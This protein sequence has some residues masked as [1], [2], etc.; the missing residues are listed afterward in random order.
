[1]MLND[2]LPYNCYHSVHVIE[3]LLRACFKYKK[4]RLTLK[5]PTRIY[6]C[7]NTHYSSSN[8]RPQIPHNIFTAYSNGYHERGSNKWLPAEPPMSMLYQS[9]FS[10]RN[11]LV[12]LLVCI[13]WILLL[14]E[15]RVWRLSVANL[16]F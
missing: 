15:T 4:K 12:C 16:S 11:L 1:M 10:K 7:G 9:V 2:L 3:M 14:Q 13:L 6:F 8:V 5:G